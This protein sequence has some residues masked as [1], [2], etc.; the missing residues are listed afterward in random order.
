MSI[1]IN[2]N[3]GG[4][5]TQNWDNVLSQGGKLTTTRTF[6]FDYNNL[7][8][9]NVQDF[10]IELKTGLVDSQHNIF[11]EEQQFFSFQKT[12]DPIYNFFYYDDQISHDKNFF[13]FSYFPNET[14][15]SLQLG[16]FQG[17]INN[18]YI[19]INDTNTLIDINAQTKV[20]INSTKIFLQCFS[21]F[22]LTTNSIEINR[23]TVGGVHT[24]SSAY[25]PV[26][27]NGVTYYLQLFN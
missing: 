11:F 8:F 24:P 21:T 25:L 13:Y 4:G 27:I 7:T 10:I 23:A 19:T 22:Q 15:F 6:N 9:Y 12:T 3:K 14:A 16:D 2:T 1:V 26:V 20:Q 17:A 18:T 5:G